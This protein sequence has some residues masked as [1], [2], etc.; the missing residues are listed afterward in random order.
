M[1]LIQTID[2]W[3]MFAQCR[4][5]HDLTLYLRAQLEVQYIGPVEVEVLTVEEAGESHIGIFHLPI[6]PIKLD[7]PYVAVIGQNS[8][9]WA[10]YIKPDLT[11]EGTN[12]YGLPI[13]DWERS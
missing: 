12:E 5:R 2:H 11:V 4:N 10:V 1:N 13:T 9:L 3:I 8:T 7:S 6:M